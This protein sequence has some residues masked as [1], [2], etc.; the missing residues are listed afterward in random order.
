MADLRRV[1][2]RPLRPGGTIGICSPAGPSPAGELERA[3]AELTRRGYRVVVAPHAA[4]HHPD[5]AYL[6]GDETQRASDLNDLLRDPAIDLILCARG[7]YGSGKLLDRLDYDAARRDPKPVVGY[8]DITALSLGLLARAG[9]VSFSGIMATSGDGFG[10]STLDPWSEASFFQA[11]ATPG[12]EPLVFVPPPDAAPWQVVR[13]PARIKGTLVPVC[14]TLLASLVGTPYVPDLRGA[15]L[16]IED[17]HEELYAIDRDLNHLRL[18]GLLDGLA[19]VLL[20]SFNG[21]A[22]E[23]NALLT[24]GVLGLVADMVPSHVA[25]ASGV[26]YGHI[27]R[28]LTLPVGAWASVDLAQATLTCQKEKFNEDTTFTPGASVGLEPD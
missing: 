26:V 21:F 22:P 2:P 11:V 17:V 7:G 3:V 18:A 27:P 20:G 19:G 16:V 12:G 6:A 15:I 9:V 28:R 5:R 1:W 14:L 13:G 10:E 23:Q 8:S 4:A 25:V 24:A